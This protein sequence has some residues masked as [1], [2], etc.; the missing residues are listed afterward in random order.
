MFSHIVFKFF[1][2]TFQVF[3]P[4]FGSANLHRFFKVVSE[5]LF[6]LRAWAGSKIIQYPAGQKK[7]QNKRQVRICLS[8]SPDGDHDPK[9][10]GIKHLLSR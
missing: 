1:K 8:K 3:S 9:A 4:V 5:L 10:R 2:I 6:P 7:V